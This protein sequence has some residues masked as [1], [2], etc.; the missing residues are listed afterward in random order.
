MKSTARPV[1]TVAV[2]GL[3]AA[4]FA[5]TPV[6]AGAVVDYARNAGKVDGRSAVGAGAGFEKR[7]GKLVATD[8]DGRLPNNII[9]TAPDAARLGGRS[10]SDFVDTCAPGVVVAA[11]LI[12]GDIGS[13]YAAVEHGYQ[14]VKSPPF[15]NGE[16]RCS[17]D[18]FQARRVTVGVYHIAFLSGLGCVSG[19]P[20][21]INVTVATVK[22][23]APL[24][25]TSNTGCDGSRVIEEIRIFD[26][27][28]V[29]RDSTFSIALLNHTPAFP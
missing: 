21:L 29:P 24:L 11:G 14:Y 25:A 8:R 2:T 6:I 10:P 4:L 5:S 27:E 3:A 1:A 16:S 7:A 17:R 28:G 12:P 26:M 20:P 22:S 9:A 13:S 18:T 15:F 19:T 23:Q